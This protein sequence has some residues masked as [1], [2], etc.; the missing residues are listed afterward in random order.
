MVRTQAASEFMEAAERPA[1]SAGRFVEAA[2]LPAASRRQ[3]VR[4]VRQR[5]V[6]VDADTFF[7]GKDCVCCIG[8]GGDERV[9]RF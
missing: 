4:P 6:W 1:A 3:R 2:E 5:R 9:R 7:L 8:K